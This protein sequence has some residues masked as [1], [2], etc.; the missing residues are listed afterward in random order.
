MLGW[1]DITTRTD[2]HLRTFR[3]KCGQLSCKM[4]PRVN[5]KYHHQST[6]NNCY[7][8]T[9]LFHYIVWVVV[10]TAELNG[11][12]AMSSRS[13][14]YPNLGQ[15]STG[16]SDHAWLASL[17]NSCCFG[18]SKSCFFSHSQCGKVKKHDFK[19]LHISYWKI[20]RIIMEHSKYA[21]QLRISRCTK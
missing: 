5:K 3:W 15:F 8:S 20:I 11:A 7:F 6:K 18:W 9:F 2:A 16:M 17:L 14:K 12:Q 19:L 1:D 13:A 10:P 21:N 4:L